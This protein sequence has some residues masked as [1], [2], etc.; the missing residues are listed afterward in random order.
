VKFKVEVIPQGTISFIQPLDVYGFRI[1]KNFVLR[2]CD[3]LILSDYEESLQ[4]RNNILK[5]QSLAH[6]Q[7]SS[8]RS[9]NM[10]K[11]AWHKNRYLSRRIGNLNL[12][13]SN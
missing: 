7:L 4:N 2:F 8:L 12:G 6:N 11:Y 1:W 5:L 13:I 9:I 3:I 10:F